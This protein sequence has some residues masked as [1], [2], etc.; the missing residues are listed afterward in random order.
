MTMRYTIFGSQ[1]YIG[2]HLNTFLTQQGHTVTC[3]L[4]GELPDEPHL[5]HII[6]CIGLTA[7]FAK[8]P[9]DTVEAHTSL[10]ARILAQYDFDTCCYLSSTRLYDSLTVEKADES[11]DLQFNPNT[12]RHLYDLSKALG[13]SIGINS[14][15][16]H[17]YAIRLASVYGGDLSSDCFIHHLIKSINQKN[18]RIDSYTNI[19]RDYINVKDVCQGLHN[20]SRH[21]KEL[22][23][24]CGIINFSS[25]ENI[26]NASL[27]SKIEHLTQSTVQ[28]NGILQSSNAA[29]ITSNGILKSQLNINPSKLIEDINRWIE[30]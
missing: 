20:I 11:T 27:F 28:H 24:N 30:C 17:V 23:G 5:G 29:P 12:P 19:A 22:T 18:F 4:K 26:S 3:P 15:K 14:G 7:D 13:E 1:G 6:Y 2:Q 8:R 25:G 10:Y 21:Y 9:F 16:Q